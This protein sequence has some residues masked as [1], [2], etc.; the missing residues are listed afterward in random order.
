MRRVG[1]QRRI[2]FAI[3]LAAVLAAASGLG[4]PASAAPS[5]AAAT[6]A[7]ASAA[8][9][10]TVAALR[11]V[12]QA[13]AEA[14]N[15]GDIDAFMQGYWQDPRLRFAS[16]DRVTYGWQPTLQSY[17]QRYPDRA[18]MGELQFSEL[19]IEVL[20]PDAALVFGHW[21]L[22]RADDRPHGLFTLL[23]RRFADGWKI[24][25]DH[26]SAAS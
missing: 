17:R 24:T 25:R 23:L 10:A 21:S 15:R 22:Q 6:A 13:Q 18:A 4:A 14:W 8:A 1:A 3:R 26:T 12:L 2:G 20:A 9:T 5:P 7:T 16:G 11:A 19:S